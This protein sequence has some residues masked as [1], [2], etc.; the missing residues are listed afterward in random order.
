MSRPPAR[1]TSAEHEADAVGRRVVN[2]RE[3]AGGDGWGGHAR[4]DREGPVL[5]PPWGGGT[6]PTRR[7]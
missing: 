2:D 5:I 7:K 4:R 6:V 1:S 3:G